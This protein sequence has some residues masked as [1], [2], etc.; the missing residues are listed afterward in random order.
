MKLLEKKHSPSDIE[1]KWYKHWIE[2][3]I[4]QV[5]NLKTIIQS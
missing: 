4:F 3:N 5:K 2:K 1:S